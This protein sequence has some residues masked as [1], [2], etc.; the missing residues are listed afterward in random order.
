MSLSEFD[1]RK[2]RLTDDCCC[3]PMGGP[4]GMGMGQPPQT[5]PTGTQPQAPN[6]FASM[7]GAQFQQPQQ[8]SQRKF[9]PELRTHN[10]TSSVIVAMTMIITVTMTA[11][12][13]MY[14][15]QLQQLNEMGFTN[16]SS[17]IQA[18]LATGGNVQ[19]AI[20]RLLQG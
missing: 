16:A 11:P 4:M 2:G 7:F 13:V 18:L 5:Q 1:V 12:E 10:H 9:V 20:E 3:R 15:S 8:P 17:N 6:P 19:A 14:A